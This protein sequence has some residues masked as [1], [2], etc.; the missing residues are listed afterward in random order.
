[1]NVMESFQNKVILSV[2]IHKLL[3]IFTG[4][5]KVKGPPK[6]IDTGGGFFLE[7][8]EEE[9]K[10]RHQTEKIVHPPG[11]LLY[12]NKYLNK[13]DIGHFGQKEPY[14]LILGSALVK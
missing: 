2:Q 10:N 7:E 11:N 3:F 14:V 8:E 4:S 5:S 6:T 13:Q 9:E 12:F 1:M